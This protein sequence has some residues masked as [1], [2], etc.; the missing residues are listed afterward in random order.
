MRRCFFYYEN[1]SNYPIKFL[2]Y[3]YPD[4]EFVILQRKYLKAQ[5]LRLELEEF[6]ENTKK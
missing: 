4:D 1:F 5:A 3:I 2:D 6:G